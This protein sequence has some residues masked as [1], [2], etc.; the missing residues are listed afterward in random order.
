MEA[1]H[2]STVAP[3]DDTQTVVL[4]I[5]DA[6]A[7][8]LVNSRIYHAE[9]PRVTGAAGSVSGYLAALEPVEGETGL[10]LSIADDILV[11]RGNPLVGASITA[12]R[13]I[14][15]ITSHGGGG[16]E[17]DSCASEHDL[18]ELLVT[19]SSRPAKGADL[20]DFDEALARQHVSGIRLLPPFVVDDREA[21]QTLARPVQVFQS[22]MDLLQDVTVSVCRGGTI[23]FGPVSGHALELLRRIDD[24]KAPLLNLAAQDQFDSF[25]FG[26]SVRVAVLAMCMARTLTKDEDLLIRIGAAALLHDCGKAL[27]PFELLHARRSLSPE[28]RREMGKHAKLGAEVLL[29]HRDADPLAIAAAF[30]H[31]R[32]C[33]GGGYPSTKR[34]HENL[35]ITE[36]VKICDV[37]EALTAARPYKRPMSPTR[38]YRVML[39]MWQHLDRQ[40][41]LR[42]ILATGIYPVGQ[43]VKLSSGSLARV[44]AQSDDLKLPRVWLLTDPAGQRLGLDAPIIIDLSAPSPERFHISEVIEERLLAAWQNSEA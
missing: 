29:D 27:V 14:Q 13:L 38:A 24:D 17:I 21:T 36:I 41:L 15:A 44:V 26:H 7:A 34:T 30:G 4:E 22:C 1:E 42:F 20:K 19:L 18:K 37:Y 40:L 23:D 6:L 2:P 5:V 39:G 12:T 32:S 28:E 11:H 8:A 16:I 31:H 33:D 35:L 9:H 10:R 43:L 25:T 3:P